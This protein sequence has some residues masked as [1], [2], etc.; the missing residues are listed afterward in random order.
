VMALAKYQVDRWKLY[1][2]YERLEFAP[3][4]DQP[5]SF[6]DIAGDCLG[7]PCGNGTALNYT[8]YNHHK[9]DQIAFVGARYALTDS[10]DVTGAY[11]HEWQNDFSGGVA[12][13]NQQGPALFCSQSTTSN[14]QCAGTKDT[15]AAVL[16][17][18]FAAKWDT[19]IGL[20]YNWNTG[21]DAN[22]FLNT[23]ELA[24]TAG[25]RFRW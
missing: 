3:A 19:Y 22:G 2:G 6:I 13:Q 14:S 16:D 7:A 20:N 4:S 21:G 15:V 12:K 11:Y 23:K 9:V 10:L 25:V 17:W 18:R 1:A 24:A 5:T 8:L